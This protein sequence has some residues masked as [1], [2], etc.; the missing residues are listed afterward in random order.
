MRTRRESRRK[1]K[2]GGFVV[3]CS[4]R[5][6]E[7]RNSAR[8]LFRLSPGCMLY[9]PIIQEQR[10]EKR[11]EAEEESIKRLKRRRGRARSTFGVVHSGWVTLYTLPPLTY[12]SVSMRM[13]R[14]ECTAR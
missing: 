10:R 12:S 5:T 11:E 7:C 13:E 14:Y 8:S 2:R 4:E 3:I 1:E 9:L 6:K